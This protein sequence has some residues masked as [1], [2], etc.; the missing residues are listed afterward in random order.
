MIT[1]V[2]TLFLDEPVP[3][4][5]ELWVDKEEVYGYLGGEVNLTCEV[6][7]EPPATLVWYHK[8]KPLHT[9]ELESPNRAIQIA[10][11]QVSAY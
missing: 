2:H 8:T 7:A 11:V 9:K 4:Y 6:I 3:A 10:L 5:P 1:S